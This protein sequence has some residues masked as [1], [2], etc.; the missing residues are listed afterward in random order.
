MR[1]RRLRFRKESHFRKYIRRNPSIIFGNEKIQW[2]DTNLPGETGNDMNADLMF[3]DSNNREVIIEVKLVEK[4]MRSKKQ[5]TYQPMRQA[6]GQIVHYA[7][8]YT[9][10][11][12]NNFPNIH[13]PP[14]NVLK[15]ASQLARLVIVTDRYAPSI[16]N[17][18]N[19]L[20]AH[21]FDIEYKYL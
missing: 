6:V 14:K 8:G 19:L 16:E 2:I 7:Y 13:S 20:H 21:G 11:V 1:K 18:C 9:K 5:H 17:M 15:H 10:K 4:A 12:C 3:R